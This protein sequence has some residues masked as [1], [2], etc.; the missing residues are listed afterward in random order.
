M[1]PAKPRNSP[2]HM[3]SLPAETAHEFPVPSNP[4]P[5]RSRRESILSNRPQPRDPPSQT[6]AA[7][8]WCAQSSDQIAPPSP[9]ACV[10]NHSPFQVSPASKDSPRA[11]A[12]PPIQIPLPNN[13]QPQA[14]TL[15]PLS[16]P[17]PAP[18]PSVPAIRS[19]APASI[20]EIPTHSAPAT[21]RREARGQ[22]ALRST[23]RAPLPPNPPPQS[24]TSPPAPAAIHIAPPAHH[25]QSISISL[26]PS[27]CVSVGAGLA[28]PVARPLGLIRP[29]HS[30]HFSPVTRPP[31]NPKKGRGEPRPYKGKMTRNRVPRPSRTG[32]SQ[33]SFPPN[34]ATRLATI[35]KPS[36]VP[37]VLVVKNGCK[38]FS[39]SLSGTPGPS[40]STANKNPSPFAEPVTLTRPPRA[41]A[42]N[43]FTT[44]FDKISLRAS[45]LAVNLVTP[46]TTSTSN[47]TPRRSASCRK[48]PL[49]S[50]ATTRASQLATT[51]PP[52]IAGRLNC[53][54]W[55]SFDD[56][57]PISSKTIFV[58]PRIDSGNSALSSCTCKIV[59]IDPSGFFKLCEMLAAICP[60]TANRSRS[61]NSL[62]SCSFSSINRHKSKA[63]GNCSHKNSNAAAVSPDNIAPCAFTRNVPKERPDC[64]MAKTSSD[65]FCTESASATLPRDSFTSASCNSSP[66]HF[67]IK[68]VSFPRLPSRATS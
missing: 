54:N 58:S 2:P 1:S 28:P 35:A 8:P 66:I 21:L 22:A 63:P 64:R 17:Y 51:T 36:P 20:S 37:C 12:T 45:E 27:H 23:P 13:P 49:T 65:G 11:A 7:F 29:N 53:S 30:R 56:N 26:P 18:K 47:A 5:Y 34:S 40:S 14:A 39:R 38:I 61:A 4:S 59:L 9:Y 48:T 3:P 15:P 43:A 68:A 25:P 60:N 16:S 50:S 32:L 10:T 24:G 31:P 6:P 46:A 52:R 57:R 62:S 44:R 41:V 42:S 67:S 55:F 33:S 19:P